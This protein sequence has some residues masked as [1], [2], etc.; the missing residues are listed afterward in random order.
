[1]ELLPHR[2]KMDSIGSELSSFITKRFAI[3]KIAVQFENVYLR[4]LKHP[5]SIETSQSVL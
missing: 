2:K 4:C 5:E 1:M 3:S